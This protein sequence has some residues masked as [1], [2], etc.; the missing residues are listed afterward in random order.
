M[1]FLRI[2]LCLAVLFSTKT[3][4][5]DV[6]SIVMDRSKEPYWVLVRVPN[7]SLETIKSKIQPGS[8]VE[9]VSWSDFKSDPV[10]YVGSVIVKNEYPD[11]NLL[12]GTLALLEKFP[13]TPF[14]ITWTGGIAFTYN[15]YRHTERIFKLYSE[16]PEEYERTKVSS[17]RRR[18]PIFPAN[19]LEPL[20]AQKPAFDHD[21]LVVILMSNETIKIL[22]QLCD[23]KFPPYSP[24]NE[25]AYLKSPYSKI[26]SER[27]IEVYGE[28]SKQ[29]GLLKG[30]EYARNSTAADFQKMDDETLKI[31]C[32]EFPQ[33]VEKLVKS[34][35]K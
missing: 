31:K 25:T 20:L 11:S 5:Q 7:E 2:L 19:H 21:R 26:V 22:K 28:S 9:I 34:L 15:D 30:L 27:A 16:H 3:M 12:K 10:M 18:D 23:E 24:Q 13:R 8:K 17:D 14:G 33:L 1:G 35:S 4:A 6:D 32:A 29:P